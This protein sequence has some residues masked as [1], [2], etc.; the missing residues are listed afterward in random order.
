MCYAMPWL[1]IA[2]TSAACTSA[3]RADKFTLRRMREIRGIRL[4]GICR[5]CCRLRCRRWRDSV[6]RQEM[7]LMFVARVPILVLEPALPIA[8]IGPIGSRPAVVERGTDERK[9]VPP[10]L[11]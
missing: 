4:C 2:S 8:G 3:R 7:G 6:G 9:V 1:S 10:L 11:E 5:Q